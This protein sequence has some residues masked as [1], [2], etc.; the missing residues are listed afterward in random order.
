MKIKSTIAFLTLFLPLIVCGQFKN[1]NTENEK[2][3]D[4]EI[5]LLNGDKLKGQLNYN[6]VS[7]VLRMKEAGNT[8]IYTSEKVLFFE[9]YNERGYVKR[10]Y[11]LPFD[12][13]NA[14]RD[15]PTFFEVVYED[16]EFALLSRHQLEYS[17][18]Q[19][20]NQDHHYGTSKVEKVFEVLYIADTKGNISPFLKR[21]KSAVDN[22]FDWDG[23]LISVDK[24][25]LEY[26]ERKL[27]S[28]STKKEVKKY[29]FVD[30]QALSQV[31]SRDK[32][33]KMEQYRKEEKL[34]LNVR[35]D[36]I[37]ALSY[38]SSIN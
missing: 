4:G 1:Y 35:K 30:K 28:S 36:L 10:F 14:G 24:P 38:Y 23:K 26:N 27:A 29:K 31:L 25:G 21:K 8:I 32:Y 13:G 16:K 7:S 20:Y 34:K 5:V 2:W 15:I 3:F 18:K 22:S 19:I 33:E 9:L 12:P 17:E 6:F 37:K 11:S